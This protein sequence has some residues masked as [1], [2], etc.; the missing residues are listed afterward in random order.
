M[1]LQSGP[2]GTSGRTRGLET[3]EQPFS[4]MQD[5]RKRSEAVGLSQVSRMLWQLTGQ[6]HEHYFLSI[7]G[8]EAVC[9]WLPW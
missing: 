4:L 7:F 1:R 5:F 8:F 3:D 6:T 9:F 2:Q